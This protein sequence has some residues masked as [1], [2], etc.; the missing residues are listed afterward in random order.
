M[1]TRNIVTI[2]AVIGLLTMTPVL[3]LQAQSRTSSAIE[4]L[5]KAKRARHPASLLGEAKVYLDISTQ[6]L[7]AHERE[8]AG[9]AIEAAINDANRGDRHNMLRHIAFAIQ[10]IRDALK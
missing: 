3:Q 8:E 9:D 2:G 4:E 7:N 1:K 6:V 5:V 10:E